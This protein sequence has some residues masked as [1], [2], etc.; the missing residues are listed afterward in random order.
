MSIT[1]ND[2]IKV[3]PDMLVCIGIG[4]LV[5]IVC[6]RHFVLALLL[7][8]LGSA[9]Y[10]VFGAFGAGTLSN[11]ISLHGPCGIAFWLGRPYIVFYL[12]P[13]AVAAT[14]VVSL[15]RLRTSRL[16]NR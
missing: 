14:L 9:A 10:G 15:W 4:C 6:R 7:S 1:W 8:I 12:L 5:G 3:L 11:E 2:F 13:T 16:T